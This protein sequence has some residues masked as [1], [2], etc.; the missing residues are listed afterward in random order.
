MGLTSPEGENFL[1]YLE[2]RQVPVVSREHLTQHEKIQVVLPSRLDEAH[3][4]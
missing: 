3:F 4:P 2:L 1:D